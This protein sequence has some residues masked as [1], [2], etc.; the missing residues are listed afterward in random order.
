MGSYYYLVAQLPYLVYGQ[1]VPISSEDFK[2]LARELMSASDAAVLEHCTLDPDPLK[3]GETEPAYTEPVH[4]TSSSLVNEWKKW[5]RTL[6]LNLAKGRAQKLKKDIPADVPDFPDD[7]A[8]VAKTA[9][10][11]ESPLEAELYLDKARWDIIENLQGIDIF[12]EKAIYGYLLKLLLMERRV[13]FDADKGFREYKGLYAA[14]LGE[15]K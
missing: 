4:K 3:E 9:L 6:R 7:A 12:C 10:V 13:M 8:L 2:A 11:M 15:K 5:E 14:I 1:D